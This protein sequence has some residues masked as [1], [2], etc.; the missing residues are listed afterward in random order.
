MGLVNSS[1]HEYLKELLSD[2]N[3]YSFEVEKGVYRNVAVKDTGLWKYIPNTNDSPTLWEVFNH[4]VDSGPNEL[5][6]GERIANA[7]GSLGDFDFMTRKQS[8]DRVSLIIGGLKQKFPYLKKGSKIGIYGKNCTDFVLIAAACWNQ[9]WIVVPIYDTFGPESVQYVVN[10]SEM[11]L[12][13]C[14]EENL[15]KVP[16]FLN[17]ESTVKGIVTFTKR[18]EVCPCIKYLCRTKC[19][20]NCKKYISSSM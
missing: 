19:F 2:E 9:G 3:Q 15:T 20:V 14:T 11:D 16:A 6:Y 10:H 7:D 1:E 5:M 12:V 17:E 4:I 8:S 18:T 13:I